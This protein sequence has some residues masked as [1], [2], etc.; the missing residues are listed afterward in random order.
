MDYLNAANPVLIDN[1][2]NPAMHT[3]ATDNIDD[4][5]GDVGVVD[6]D[7]FIFITAGGHHM[8]E[9][10]GAEATQMRKRLKL[11]LI[12]GDQATQLRKRLK[13]IEGD[14]VQFMCNQ[15]TEEVILEYPEYDANHATIDD[16]ATANRKINNNTGKAPTRVKAS[17]NKIKSLSKGMLVLAYGMLLSP[18]GAIFPYGVCWWVCWGLCEATCM[19]VPPA[20]AFCIAMH[21]SSGGTACGAGCTALAVLPIPC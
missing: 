2:A 13:L 1:C 3:V 20:T 19:L 12:E 18:A 10:N 4:L 15:T 11:K 5:S 14:R 6:E 9:L 17:S 7:A 16:G 8:I 21:V